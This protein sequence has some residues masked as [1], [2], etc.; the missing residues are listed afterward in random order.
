MNVDA[1]LRLLI[2][3]LVED[4]E[5]GRTKVSVGDLQRVLTLAEQMDRSVPKEIEV[6]W[7]E[8]SRAGT[9]EE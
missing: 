8:E 6:R 9:G 7:I 3:R 5:C 1:I 2:E 4:I